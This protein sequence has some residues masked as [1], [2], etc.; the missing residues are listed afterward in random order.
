MNVN[1]ISIAFTKILSK[2]LFYLE[3]KIYSFFFFNTRKFW[4]EAC[5]LSRSETT[6]CNISFV[7]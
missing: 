1:A 4:A 5:N 3:F 6:T 7:L 2:Y